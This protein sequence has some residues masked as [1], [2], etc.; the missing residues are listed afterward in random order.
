MIC[1]HMLPTIARRCFVM[2]G[3]ELVMFSIVGAVPAAAQ[4]A[5]GIS[6]SQLALDSSADVCTGK[7]A[8]YV[9]KTYIPQSPYS[10]APLRCGTAAY[11][12]NHIKDRWNSAFDQSIQDTLSNAQK[13][14]Q[15]GSSVTFVLD[16]LAPCPGSFRVVVEY[17][18]YGS[19]P[20]GIIT[21][22]ESSSTAIAAEQ[23]HL[24]KHAVCG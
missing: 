13:K 9:V 4:D 1:M 5:W 16:Y 2:L 22:Y 17:S 8:G 21:A 10:P 6:G 19:G 3:V 7:A 18:E 20:K 23:P 14:E 11:G 24:D 15:S 12:F